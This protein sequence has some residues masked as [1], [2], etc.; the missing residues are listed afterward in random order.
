MEHG[1]SVSDKTWVPSWD[2]KAES[3]SH[4]I[5][6]VKWTLCSTKKEEK[7]L[8]AARIVRKALQSSHSA[9]V[10]LMY[11]FNP[12]DFNS[13]ADVNKLMKF[14][15]ESPLNRQP[16][17]DAGAKIGGYYRRL[18]KKNHESVSAFLIRED[19]VHGDMLKALQRLLREK[20][21]D[22]DNYD[23]D[24][25]EL[26]AFCG[27]DPNMSVYYPA[28]EVES[29]LGAE[30][31]PAEGAR[32]EETADGAP[33]EEPGRG[34]KGKGRGD[35]TPTARRTST[36]SQSSSTRKKSTVRGKDLLERLME[37]GLVPLAALD[38]IRGWLLLEMATA[39]EEDR[40]VVK[41]ATRNR[42]SY[43]EIRAA[44]LSMYEERD[45]KGSGGTGKGKGPMF[46]QD[47]NLE[48]LRYQDYGAYDTDWDYECGNSDVGL[49][50][51]RWTSFVMELGG[52]VI[53]VG[54]PWRCLRGGPWTSSLART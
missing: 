27:H 23:V 36:S 50:P 2:G 47:G 10:A 11:K 48:D 31:E 42:L 1:T 25:D 46:Y 24:V 53:L 52:R 54:G 35:G 4:F 21:L 34:G 32:D 38:V 16:L 17:P 33:D 39:S 14:L 18:H 29:E 15:E 51:G 22:F 3:F 12:E 44:L 30:S 5:T 43:N 19:K 40:R 41:A 37:K 26:K 9:L 7:P 13:E 8:L 49:L 20:E 45:R 28:D 6:E